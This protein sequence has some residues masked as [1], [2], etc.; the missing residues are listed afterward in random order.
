MF[1]WYFVIL[2][3]KSYRFLNFWK[4]SDYFSVFLYFGK[5]L[6]FFSE[7]FIYFFNFWNF[8]EYVYDFFL[9]I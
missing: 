3:K 9:K 2:E 4:K 1:L 6:M 7:F 5:I 8:F